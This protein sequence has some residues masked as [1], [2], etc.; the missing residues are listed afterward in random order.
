[1]S[2]SLS[3]FLAFFI[4][5]GFVLTL[6]FIALSFSVFAQEAQDGTGDEESG[7]E[8]TVIADVNVYNA[9]LSEQNGNEFSVSFDI[10]NG[11]GAQSQIRYA[12][13][14]LRQNVDGSQALLDRHIY[15][16]TIALSENKRVRKTVSY[17]APDYLK[18]KDLQLWVVAFN[19]QGL[20]LGH[21]MAGTVNLTAVRDYIEMSPERCS[22]SVSGEERIFTLIEGPDVSMT[23]KLLLTCTLTNHFPTE[24]TF[25]PHFAT[26]RRAA[27]GGD[28]VKEETTDE[29]FTII[30]KETKEIALT[31]PVMS[32]PQAYDTVLTLQKKDS[33]EDLSNSIT[34]HYVT[35]GKSA[36]IS[37]VS[38]DKNTYNKGDTAQITVTWSG[39]ADN[40][41][42][43]RSEGTDV[44][45]VTLTASLTSGADD[46]CSSPVSKTLN[47][48]ASVE[49][50]SAQV[51]QKCVSPTVTATI[52]DQSGMVLSNAS[53]AFAKATL[54]QDAEQIGGVFSDV[55]M[56][57]RFILLATVVLVILI[58]GGVVWQ[59]RK[60]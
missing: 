58:A 14:L 48:G 35:R 31:I 16:E 30:A 7:G 40:F 12:I 6:T 34:A 36:T 51:S 27:L 26:Y 18:G 3:R 59:K 32:L 50:L 1:M 42:D 23:D 33:G 17:T 19:D 43:A 56:P 60:K 28:M 45:P 11:K 54:Q 29:S 41:P 25:S 55:P 13:D 24:V 37:N 52:T 49:T 8:V 20:L 4:T 22:L 5:I 57:V 47:V 44:G 53:F 15:P 39:A 38:I 46:E 9:S 21:N 2:R 10:T